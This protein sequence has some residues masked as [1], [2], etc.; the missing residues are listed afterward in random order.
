MAYTKK[1][2][3]IIITFL[4]FAGISWDLNPGHWYDLWRFIFFVIIAIEA[5]FIENND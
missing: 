4:L 5:Y 1:I 2:L 3:T